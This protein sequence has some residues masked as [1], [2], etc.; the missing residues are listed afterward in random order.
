MGVACRLEDILQDIVGYHKGARERSCV[1]EEP[2]SRIPHHFL[3]ER[4]NVS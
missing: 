3:P 1:T 4:L 2:S